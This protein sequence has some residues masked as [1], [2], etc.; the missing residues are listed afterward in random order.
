[1]VLCSISGEVPVTPVV[2]TKSGHVFEKSLI[3]KHL[4]VTGQC[5]V[6][7]EELSVAD[8]MPIKTT[9]A[10]KPRP[11]SATSV[12][13]LIQLFQTEWDSV[14]LETYTLK[15]HLD[16]VRQELAH[17]LYQYDASC[18]VIARLVKER[19]EARAA[20]NNTQDN[21]A[22][23]M[24]KAAGGAAGGSGI[25]GAVADTMKEVATSLSKNR[26]KRVKE[27]AAEVTKADK[28]KKYTSTASHPLHSPSVPGILCMDLH[29]ADQNLV[30]TGGADTNAVVFNHSSGKIVDTL[31]GHKKK[32]TSV[33]F[34]ATEKT[35]FTTSADST[36]TVWTADA[37]SG[38]YSAAHTFTNHTAE[39]AGCTLH[40]SGQYLVAASMDKTWSFYDVVA[41]VCRQQ[42][43]DAKITGG[44]TQVSFHPDGLILGAGTADS[45]VRIFDVKAQKNVANFKG[46]SGKVSALSFSENGYYLASGDEKGTIKLWDLRKL[47][48]FQTINPKGCSDGVGSLEFD[49]SGSYL[50][51]GGSQVSV[52]ASKG[53]DVVQSWSDH[54]KAV[55]AVKFA[56]GAQWFATASKDRSLKIF[57]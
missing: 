53:W 1:M 44:Y 42:V 46:H 15:Q 34:H 33:K 7:K 30:V 8:L 22:A 10:V 17:A 12:P 32:I 41:G 9:T 55:T 56:K 18:R 28:I 14:M 27:L 57:S 43:A 54:S 21:V 3:E 31:K 4:Q 11:P 38:K 39:V 23:A 6:T 45:V 40:P 51:V 2:S 36:T 24:S 26:R 25:T 16:T 20:L 29:K 19:D 49:E 5:P 37:K 13:G 47:Q 52:Y 48:N 50:G 35:V